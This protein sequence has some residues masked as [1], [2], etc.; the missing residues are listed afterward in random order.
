MAREKVQIFV[1]VLNKIERNLIVHPLSSD[2]CK[3]S[4]TIK[5][6]LLLCSTNKHVDMSLSFNPVM[7]SKMM[8]YLTVFKLST[9]LVTKQLSST[10]FKIVCPY[11]TGSGGYHSN[12]QVLDMS[13]NNISM[14]GKKFFRPA[15][16]SLTNLY[17]SHNRIIN[18]T[19][20]VFGN[21]P[22][23]QW[24][25]LSRNHIYEMDFDMFRNTK[26]LQVS[27]IKSCR[28]HMAKYVKILSRFFS[29]DKR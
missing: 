27:S 29:K 19:R 2:G 22:H 7:E 17:L 14:I 11:C 13:F 25:D 6:I 4:S 10:N 1:A 18:A 26:K 9:T 15:E 16:I 28:V 5:L 23:L 8:R 24:L 12:I 3:L 21:M 20:E